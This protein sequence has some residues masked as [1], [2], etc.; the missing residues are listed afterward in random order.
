MLRITFSFV[1]PGR[2][3]F[4][5]TPCLSISCSRRLLPTLRRRV[6]QVSWLT[7]DRRPSKVVKSKSSLRHNSY[8]TSLMSIP[9]LQRHT[10]RT[11]R[12]R[13]RSFVSRR[14]VS[15]SDRPYHSCLKRNFG[16]DTFS[17][18]FSIR[19][20]LP[21]A[22]RHHNMLSKTTQSLTSI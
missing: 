22:P 7:R 17:Q 18:N 5:V 10:T 3:N 14:C 19:I 13:Y 1:R 11:C 20:V 6:D 8:T 21:S 4:D 16:S 9:S 12:A 2:V 15:V